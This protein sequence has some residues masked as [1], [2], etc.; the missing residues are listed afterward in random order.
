M[1]T[2]R[3]SA[4][5]SSPISSTELVMTCRVALLPSTISALEA[6]SE[7]R[8]SS[9]Y[10]TTF[11]ERSYNAWRATS[12]SPASPAEFFAPALGS[13][14]AAAVLSK[15]I[16]HSPLEDELSIGRSLAREQCSNVRQSKT[17]RGHSLR[18]GHSSLTIR[19]AKAH[20]ET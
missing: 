17:D 2:G 7:R 15:G 10:A 8:N 14:F 18:R 20:P 11:F 3:S 13:I 19:G 5:R 16:F 1:C 6:C 9:S 4:S 12:S